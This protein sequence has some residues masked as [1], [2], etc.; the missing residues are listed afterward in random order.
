MRQE[1]IAKADVR[2]SIRQGAVEPVTPKSSGG[3]EMCKASWKDRSWLCP[4]ADKYFPHRVVVGDARAVKAVLK[5][6]SRTTD[7]EA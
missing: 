5:M 6:E 3:R 4:A 2:P 1:S 7:L